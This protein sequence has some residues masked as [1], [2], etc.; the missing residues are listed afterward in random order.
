MKLAAQPSQTSPAIRLLTAADVQAY[1][2]LRQRVLQLGDG[3]YFSDSYM[4]EKQLTNDRLWRDW[5]SEK[6]DHCIFGTFID[7]E[8]IG[9]MMITHYDGFGDR[10]VEWEAIWLDPRYRQRGFAKL[11]YD[12]LQHWTN[13]HG[14]KRVVL[15]IR[16]DNLRS[17]YIH[18]KLGACYISTKRNEVWADGSIADAHSFILDLRKPARE[19]HQQDALLHLRDTLSFLRSVNIPAPDPVSASGHLSPATATVETL[20]SEASRRRDPDGDR[21]LLSGTSPRNSA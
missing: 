8:L 9:V 20:Y 13:D 15:F 21:L 1:R 5:C 2:A 10:T 19:T 17:L 3:R 6:P 11:A 7:G 16:A 4:R 12:Q 18:Q 14:F